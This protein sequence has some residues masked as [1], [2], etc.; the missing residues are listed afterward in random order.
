MNIHLAT[1]TSCRLVCVLYKYVD[2][3]PALIIGMEELRAQAAMIG[4]EDP[5]AEF[6]SSSTFQEVA[7][8]GVEVK[9]RHR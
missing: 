8:D 7:P 9:E 5:V 6:L 1:P 4:D 3:N 2:E